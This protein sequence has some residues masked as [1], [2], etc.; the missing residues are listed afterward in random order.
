MS[1]PLPAPGYIRNT[2]RTVSDAQTEW[3]LDIAVAK[4]TLGGTSEGATLSITSNTITPV[5]DYCVYPVDASGGGTINT[6]NV[7]NMRDG[8]LLFLH[9]VTSSDP[10]TIANMV[11]GSGVQIATFSGRNIVLTNPAQFVALKYN[12]SANVFQEMFPQPNWGAPGPIGSSTASTGTFTSISVT[13]NVAAGTIFGNFGSSSAAPS[14]TAPG[15]TDQLLGV[16]HSGGGLEYKSI[17][18]GSN[19]TITPASGSITIAATGSSESEIFSALIMQSLAIPAVPSITQHGTAGSTVYGYAVTAVLADGSTQTAISPIATTITGNATLSPSN[20]NT[21]SWSSISGAASYTVYRTTGGGSSGKIG[22]TASTSLNDTGLSGDSSIPPFYNNTGRIQGIDSLSIF[23]GASGLRQLPCAI[24][25]A[26]TV[27]H[28]GV[29]GSTDY[30]YAVSAVMA[31]GTTITQASPT[32]QTTTGN[33]T[34]STANYNVV[35]WTAVAGAWSYNIYRT[36]SAGSPSTTGLIGNTTGTSFNDTGIAG[37]VAAPTTTIITGEYWHLGNWV[38]PGTIT[39]NYARLHVAGTVTFNNNWICNTECS[40]GIYCATSSSTTSYGGGNGAGLGGGL[41]GGP[42]QGIYTPDYALVVGGGGG[43]HGGL[44]GSASS[45]YIGSGGTYPISSLLTGSGGGAGGAIAGTSGSPGGNGGGSF[46]LE[47]TGITTSGTFTIAA[48]GG[49]GG[50]L[51]GYGGGG[52]SGGG[53][54]WRV[55]GP[56]DIGSGCTISAN[57]GSGGTGTYSSGG[58]GGGGIIDLSGYPISNSGTITA[59]GGSTSGSATVG[60]TGIVNFNSFIQ[61]VRSAG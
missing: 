3:E 27:S 21:I 33:A 34:L 25:S 50:A 49:S 12:E 54:Q 36:S 2:S 31:D 38:Q 40:G 59:T 39:S 53:I 51:G 23:G 52:G 46:Y 60:A 13:G 16:A 7:S 9:C 26:P 37:T 20:Y 1:G 18:A 10:I 58:G 6:I 56:I 55:L 45:Q 8:Q 22:Q 44:G 19:I 32:T 30:T 15:S 43:G 57:G 17:V 29:T 4:E 14:F 35:S 5:D 24:P 47:C 28:G 61:S 48:N 41:G 11:S 42:V